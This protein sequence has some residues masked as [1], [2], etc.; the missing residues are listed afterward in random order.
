M[1]PG[2]F[3]FYFSIPRPNFL[4][5][6]IDILPAEDPGLV[7]RGWLCTWSL[8]ENSHI[9]ALSSETSPRPP[10]GTQQLG[11]VRALPSPRSSLLEPSVSGSC[12]PC[13]VEKAMVYTD[14]GSRIQ[15]SGIQTPGVFT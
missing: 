8:E 10:G 12:A 13:W 6:E 15:E 3:L 7:P 14:L 11:S 9:Q 4:T 1:E 2:R 5:A